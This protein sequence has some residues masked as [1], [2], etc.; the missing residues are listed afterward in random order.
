MGKLDFGDGYIWD[1]EE[2]KYL[3]IK[4]K[5]II[6][7][8]KE[9]YPDIVTMDFETDPGNLRIGFQQWGPESKFCLFLGN[10]G[11]DTFWVNNVQ[12]KTNV[13]NNGKINQGTLNEELIQLYE[14]IDNLI[15]DYSR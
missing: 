9:K 14:V 1:E 6:G 11:Q 13:K 7:K 15:L 2:F 4:T 12:F 10:K 3:K 8:L 5:V